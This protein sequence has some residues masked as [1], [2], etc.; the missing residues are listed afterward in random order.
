M[1]AGRRRIGPVQQ[2]LRVDDAADLV[3]TID[4]RVPGVSQA[5]IARA[6]RR[7]VDGD[8]VDVTRGIIACSTAIR[9][10]ED[11]IEA[12]STATARAVPGFPRFGDD[13]FESRGVSIF[14]IVD[15]F[16]VQQSQQGSAALSNG[17]DRA[18]TAR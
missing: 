1:T 9:K 14:D 16:D 5:L 6:P 13:V 17:D 12:A 15:G 8:G 11:P 10:V 3:R 7:V 2:D 18:N 4:H